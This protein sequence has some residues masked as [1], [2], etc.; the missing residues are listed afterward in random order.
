MLSAAVSAYVEDRAARGEIGPNT[1]RQLRVRL[2]T[3]VAACPPGQLVVNVDRDTIR[4]WQRTIGHH[5]PATRRAYLSTVRRFC[6]WAVDW[7]LM[8]ADPTLGVARV[9]ESRREPR[10]LSSAQLN[11]LW[12]VLPDRR[13]RLIVELMV[14]LGLRCV[15]VSR[16]AVADY[17]AGRA[18]VLVVGKKDHERL[19][20][21]PP[22]VAAAL[23][24]WL[25]TSCALNR[26]T[27]PIVG[28]SAGRISALMSIWMRQAGIK[29]ASW[30]RVSAH[31]LRH[32]FASD[33]LDRCHNVRTV[34]AAL[35]HV[36]LATTERYLRRASLD[37]MRAAMDGNW[38]PAA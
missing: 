16:L 35:G 13:A 31:A 5:T 21:V 36:S 28:L 10:A 15:E 17:D 25:A 38:Q 2:A 24:D 23:D 4:A 22:A 1:A 26:A 11:R 18:T 20:P 3:L 8:A 37:Q 7:S 30:D 33:M 34:Q 12:L 9:V 29:S 6:A 19:L 32:T 27:G 14:G